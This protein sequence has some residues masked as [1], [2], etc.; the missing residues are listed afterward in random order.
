MLSLLKE[1]GFNE[2]QIV[3]VKDILNDRNKYFS[4]KQIE[5]RFN[6]SNQTARNDLT[7]LVKNGVLVEKQSGRKSQ[8]SLLRILIRR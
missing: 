2:R 3:I 6:V 8:F 7:G 4:V 5:S 1:T